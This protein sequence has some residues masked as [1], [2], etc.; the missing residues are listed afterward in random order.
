MHDP[1][2][3]QAK[4]GSEKC[5]PY[6][7]LWRVSLFGLAFRLCEQSFEVDQRQEESMKVMTMRTLIAVAI[8]VAMTGA[9][10]A[11]SDDK[12]KPCDSTT[13]KGS[14]VFTASGFQIIGGVAQ[15]K[16]IM[17]L[18]DFNGDGT[19]TVPGGVL[20]LNGVITHIPPTGVGNYTVGP[21]CTGTLLFT[22]GPSFSFVVDSNGKSGPMIQT[23]T[24]SIFQGTL[25]RRK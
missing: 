11:E 6:P 15:P 4:S 5:S 3:F 9:A 16:A 18:I 10:S 1:S 21:D 19:L 17:E 2:A 13:L 22:G 12:G 24:N 20:S 8:A 25:A 23:N 7:R 14:Y